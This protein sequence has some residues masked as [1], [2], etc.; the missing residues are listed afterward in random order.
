[1]ISAPRDLGELSR[2]FSAINDAFGSNDF[3]GLSKLAPHATDDL[4]A[5][6][7]LARLLPWADFGSLIP[8]SLPLAEREQARRAIEASVLV[9]WDNLDELCRTDDDDDPDEDEEEEEL[10]GLGSAAGAQDSGPRASPFA[11][12][13][14]KALALIAEAPGALESCRQAVFSPDYGWSGIDGQTQSA[15][16]AFI[17]QATAT[18]RSAQGDHLLGRLAAYAVA[19]GSA[20]TE[21]LLGVVPAEALSAPQ[22]DA[23]L[24]SL[25]HGFD[26]PRHIGFTPKEE[27]KAF[28]ALG[29]EAGRQVSRLVAAGWTGEAELA[30]RLSVSLW[31]DERWLA[32]VHPELCAEFARALHAIAPGRP[33]WP[34]WIEAARDRAEDASGASVREAR[35]GQALRVFQ[36]IEADLE[37]RELLRSADA[38]SR[39]GRDASDGVSPADPAALSRRI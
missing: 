14:A 7:E 35:W 18:R 37:R 26:S 19:R 29:Q 3:D 21:L 8:A 39:A 2:F 31:G 23:L 5:A 9:F 13:L 16:L 34:E 33:E 25:A 17:A 10:D 20:A 38:G 4:V 22:R 6:G 11:R 24:F 15:Y 30:A 36:T 32:G 27:A 1:M 12:S 28:I